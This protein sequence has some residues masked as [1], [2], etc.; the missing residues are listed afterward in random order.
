[1]ILSAETL[2]A[3]KSEFAASASRRRNSAALILAAC[4]V[5]AIAIAVMVRID[6]KKPTRDPVL[7]V[8]SPDNEVSAVVYEL[9]GDA[10]SSFRYQVEV[11][12]N[13]KAQVVAG[14]S[15]ALR[16]DRAYGVTPEWLSNT[17]LSI[18]Y[19]TAQQQQLLLP[20]V[21]LANRTVKVTLHSGVKDPDAPAGGMLFNLRQAR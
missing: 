16:N 13:G 21:T 3:S 2:S 17:E 9:S 1:M 10:K 20:A 7:R 19:L 8:L 6:P 5:A 11:S 12:A 4:V 14:F 15:G 18:D